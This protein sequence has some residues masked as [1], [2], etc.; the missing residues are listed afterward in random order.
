MHKLGRDQCI[1]VTRTL[2]LFGTKFPRS[3]CYSFILEYSFLVLVSWDFAEWIRVLWEHLACIRYLQAFIHSEFFVLGITVNLP[4]RCST[5][6]T[7]TSNGCSEISGST[8]S[9]C[10]TRVRRPASSTCPVTPSATCCRTTAACRPT[11]SSSSLTGASGKRFGHVGVSQDYGSIAY[12]TRLNRI[13]VLD[14]WS[15]FTRKLIESPC[16]L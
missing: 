16:V 15:R 3:T 4:R 6:P 8:S 5:D 14:S 2:V 10:L 7:W 1:F 11:N 9:T 13:V 12:L